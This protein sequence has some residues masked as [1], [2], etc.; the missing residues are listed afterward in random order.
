MLYSV[1]VH[2]R[3][4]FDADSISKLESIKSILDI[5]EDLSLKLVNHY[6]IKSDSE[7]DIDLVSNNV[8]SEQNVDIVIQENMNFDDYDFVLPV[9]ALL[10][11]FD[12]R[13]KS[14]A[15][16][17]SIL[18]EQSNIDLRTAVLYCFKGNLSN[19]TK[20]KIEKIIVNP[21]ENEKIST[22]DLTVFLENDAEVKPVKELDELANLK[23]KD[24]DDY[25]NKMSL[26]MNA[27]DLKMVADYFK[28]EG[29]VPTEVE[30]RVLDTYWSDHCR[31]TTF[32]TKIKSISLESENN[33]SLIETYNKYLQYRE[34]LNIENRDISLM[35]LA[36][37]YTKVLR[38]AGKMDDLDVSE[39]INACSINIPVTMND[40]SKQDMLLMFKN[41]T[42]NHP[43]EI[44]PYGG[45]AT[46]LGGAIRD[47][48]SGRAYVYGA[49]RVTGA[50]NPKAHISN[51]LE[52]KLPQ[53]KICRDAAKGYSSYGNQMGIAT[54]LVREFYHEGFLA[55][56]MEVG[57]VIAS[58]KKENVIREVPE[59]GDV[60]ILVG[61]RTG[62]DGVGGATGSSKSHDEKSIVT[63]SSEVQKGNPPT[64]RKIIRLF[65]NEKAS[66]MI[67]RC[68]DFGAGGVA[69]AVGE[70]ADSL[71]INLDKVT[72]KYDGLNAV[73]LAI[74]ESQERMAVVVAKENADEFIREAE[75]E[76]LEANIIATVTDTGRLIMKFDGKTVFDISRD[77]IDS[78]G[79]PREMSIAV[80]ESENLTDFFFGV[81]E[82]YLQNLSSELSDIRNSSQKGLIEMFDCSIGARTVTAAL[83]G[84]NQITES[85]AMIHYI[86]VGDQNSKTMSLMT[87]FYD[88]YLAERSPY[89]G[90]YYAV[91]GS[92]ARVVA[93]GFDYKKTRLTFQEYFE[94]LGSD[95]VKWGKPFSALLGALHVE[96]AF[97]I[98]AIGGKD[99]MSGTFED[100]N[101]P[102]TLISFAVSTSNDMP[103]PNV[104]EDVD[105]SIYMLNLQ[106]NEE[107]GLDLDSVKSAY[108]TILQ[109]K[110]KILCMKA[111]DHKG[112]VINAMEMG[113][114]NSV[115]ISFN[116]NINNE[117]LKNY[118][119]ILIQSRDNLEDILPVIKIGQTNTTGGFDFEG[120]NYHID[121]LLDIYKNGLDSV[122]EISRGSEEEIETLSHNVKDV[123]KSK[124]CMNPLVF[125]PVFPGTNC[126]HDTKRAFEKAGARVRTE[127]FKNLTIE[128][129]KE[130]IDRFESA[131]HECNIIA[132]PGGFSAGD[133]PEGSAKFIATV[134]RNEKIKKA[135][136]RHLN[137]DDGLIIGICNGFQ[138]LIK[139][140]LF[141]HDSIS[142]LDTD[143]PTL[144]YNKIAR[145]V[146]KSVNTRIASVN[147][148]W[149]YGLNVGDIHTVYVSN[150][151]GRVMIN[152]DV[153]RDFVKNGQIFSQYVDANGKATM[154]G[155]DNPSSSMYAIEGL[156]SKNGR[157][158]GKM[159]HSERVDSGLY[160]NNKANYNNGIFENGV[161][162][163]MGDKN[164]SSCNNGKRF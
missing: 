104:L 66:K 85:D 5:K 111:V 60:V 29:R 89:Y 161:K 58:A 137:E 122:Y 36:T 142:D 32:N 51:T 81:D 65:M 108:D 20:K 7:I 61:G 25:I 34:D 146:S 63:S 35:Q 44:E 84:K 136:D 164:E 26:A 11:Q 18:T 96:D 45:A 110:D 109:N 21:I 30:L 127:V 31:H 64:E 40:D 149:L 83:G 56:R 10:G 99:S 57:A 62:R 6:L 72:K 78:A 39:E 114:G 28:K 119:S 160:I 162:Y 112:F 15:D 4:G 47:P 116:A 156:I 135:I 42:H 130:S 54:G 71:E 74:S 24:Y 155:E 145:H 153:Y 157:V 33:K 82:M 134:F 14:G 129:I 27:D 128:D 143:S 126:E 107:G 52:G 90:A 77:F 121:H 43:T 118:G 93:S 2:K 19:E 117:V 3:D 23:D 12:L 87:F 41:E 55:K 150:G 88:P 37:I 124:Y 46:C 147:S 98:S 16:C 101:V 106:R 113:F 1:F 120:I 80:E 73:E 123:M 68:N 70:I 59:K 141:E 22:N 158:L 97:E 94:K 140:G 91:L 13:A 50:E 103:I 49:M 38:N 152:K 159:G 115:G 17:I 102:P 95:P 151:E 92:I 9:R 105:S 138:A 100:I 79:A 133:E 144:T 76:N 154:D 69:V 48:L 125:I 132:I 139:L 53:Y 8:L 163:F 86:P 67:K 131:I 75:R 148:P